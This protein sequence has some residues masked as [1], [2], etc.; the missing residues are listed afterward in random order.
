MFSFNDLGSDDFA[1]FDDDDI[2]EG[3]SISKFSEGLLENR[4]NQPENNILINNR[5]LTGYQNQNIVDKEE[6]LTNIKEF[7]KELKYLRTTKIEDE[8]MD[9][10]RKVGIKRLCRNFNI[11][12]I[13]YEYSDGSIK[14][15]E[16]YYLLVQCLSNIEY[17]LKGIEYDYLDILRETESIVQED[18]LSMLVNSFKDDIFE[19]TGV[20]KPLSFLRFLLTIKFQQISALLLKLI[21]FEKE[22]M[23]IILKAISENSV[24]EINHIMSKELMKEYI[25]NRPSDILVTL[26]LAELLDN[27]S[28]QR[29]SFNPEKDSRVILR[30]SKYFKDLNSS[31]C[32]KVFYLMQYWVK[33][34]TFDSNLEDALYILMKVIMNGYNF[35]LQ[36][37]VVSWCS[38]S[39]LKFREKLFKIF[40]VFNTLDNKSI[41]EVLKH[42]HLFYDVRL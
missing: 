6:N 9:L 1:T 32:T 29:V 37:E 24:D 36:L 30:A 38:R 22:R 34:N 2:E 27:E 16:T 42:S 17:E 11:D 39:N 20:E 19:D 14:D 8:E 28:L 10:E 4:I 23:M 3:Q 7:L 18:S 15:S 13:N 35:D 5:Q 40:Y 26:S 12:F 31:D 41:N 25:K 33:N 21:K